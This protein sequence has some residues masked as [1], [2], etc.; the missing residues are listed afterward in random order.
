M[1]TYVGRIW[2][3]YRAGPDAPP[4]GAATVELATWGGGRGTAWQLGARFGMIWAAMPRWGDC[5]PP[6]PASS[7][8]FCN[9]ALAARHFDVLRASLDRGALPG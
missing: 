5:T 4:A 6:H 8:T 2:D 3:S 7:R 9:A 1:T